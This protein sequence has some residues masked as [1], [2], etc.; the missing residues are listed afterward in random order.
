M[1]SQYY[2]QFKFAWRPKYER[3]FLRMPQFKQV[4]IS[5]LFSAKNN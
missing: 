5:S 3:I 2:L 4:N 1:N